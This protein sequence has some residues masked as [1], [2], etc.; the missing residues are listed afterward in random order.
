MRLVVGLTLYAIT[1]LILFLIGRV[2]WAWIEADN[3][4]AYTLFFVAL[5]ALSWLIDSPANKTAV[6]ASVSAWRDRMRGRWGLR[7]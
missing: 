1:G 7:W 3:L 2:L 5:A 4:T 6:R